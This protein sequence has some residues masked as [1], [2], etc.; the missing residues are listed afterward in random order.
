MPELRP[1][2]VV[3]GGRSRRTAP[4]VGVPPARATGVCCR[5]GAIARSDALARE[6]P[7]VSGVRAASVRDQLGWSVARTLGRRRIAALERARGHARKVV[8]GGRISQ[9]G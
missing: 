2:A 4:G 5:R 9:R 7:A 8:F 6:A 1:D 3:A